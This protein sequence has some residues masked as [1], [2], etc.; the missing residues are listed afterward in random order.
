[1]NVRIEMGYLNGI[2][3]LVSF[4]GIR[5]ERVLKDNIFVWQEA[6]GL[7]HVTQQASPACDCH[8]ERRLCFFKDEHQMHELRFPS[9][10]ISF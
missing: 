10:F 5:F 1:M 3:G 8:S 9:R 2:F 7:R 6:S 4:G